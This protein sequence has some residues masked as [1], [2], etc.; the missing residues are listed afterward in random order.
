MLGVTER[1][2]SVPI[3]CGTVGVNESLWAVHLIGAIRRPGEWLLRLKIVGT[4]SPEREVTVRVAADSSNTVT[5]Q[6]VM[7]AVRTWL[8]AGDADGPGV[9]DLVN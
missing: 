2:F 5:A 6:R 1:E 3:P 4:E 9:L 8:S 7:N